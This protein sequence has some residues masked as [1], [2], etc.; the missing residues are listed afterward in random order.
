MPKLTKTAVD[1]MPLPASGDAW[2]WDTELQGFGVRCHASGRKTYLIR[3]RAKANN[4]QRKL[5]LA[6]CSD[7][8]PDKARELARKEF[9]RIAAGEDPVG[10]RRAQEEAP[11]VAEMEVR[12][13][14]DH[15]RPFKKAKSVA[16]DEKNW[17]LHI[18]PAMGTRKV[19]EVTRSQVLT[20]VGNMSE[21]PATA[22]QCLALLSKAFNL[23]EDWDWRPRNSNPCS[24]IKKYKLQERET[25]LSPKDIGRL[26]ETL[27][28]LLVENAIS[29]PM[30]NLVRLLMLTGCRLREI[31]HAR[32]EW[33]DHER[34]L[35]IL[36]DS[37]TGQR[38]IPLSPA[39]MAIIST[40]QEG[41]E[42]LIPG[43]CKDAPMETPYKAWALIKQRAG[44]PA[45]MRIHD[46]RHTVG[47]LG[48]MAGLSQKQIATMLGHA[49]L[50]TT[51]RYLH[52][53]TGDAAVVAD[54]I[55]SMIT[56]A[57]DADK[58]DAA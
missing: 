43:R 33:V 41:Q 54:K 1:N 32:R 26:N 31:M 5:T 47:S 50:S 39:C 8:P 40:M 16:L 56:L 20:F 7:M 49:Q 27:T 36:P 6:R 53:M 3:Y 17:R 52:G 48:H 22:N 13:M 45:E 28:T 44:L 19:N 37:K 15:A 35:L 42:W 58:V 10:D 18:L 21:T 24:R 57:W 9:A 25:I 4:K 12:Y 11:T 34:S 38:R 29:Q 2:L 23:A 30:A 46:L 55:G 51:E 14:K